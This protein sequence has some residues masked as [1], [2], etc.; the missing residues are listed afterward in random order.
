MAFGDL[1]G[2]LSAA[3]AAVTATNS[4]TGSVS[5]A[6]GDLVFLTF[7]QQANLRA[8]TVV[9]NLGNTY[10]ATNA[11]T[12]AGNITGRSYYSPVTVAGTLTSIDVSVSATSNDDW[13]GFAAV[14]EGPFQAA[15][16]DK[17]I[18]NAS[19]DL[20]SPFTCPATGA[21]TQAD[22][23]IIAWMTSDGNA[24]WLATSPNLKAG[25]VAN[26][27]TI[28]AIVGYQA[29]SATTTV[30]PEFTGTNPGFSVLGTSTFMKAAG[31]KTIAIDTGAHTFAGTAV[32]LKQARKVVAGSG[33]HSFSG[34]NVTLK[35]G[36]KVA[37]GTG[38][39]S[40]TG[41]SVTLRHAWRV[42]AG[43]GA[44]T[45][46]GT[47]VNLKHG[48]K[49][50]AGSGAHTFAGTDVTL[51]LSATKKIIAGAGAHSFAG[52]AV[53]LR[54]AWRL[55]AGAG[56][57]SFTGTSVTLKHA[58]KIGVDIGAHTF[59]GTDI[60]VTI[61]AAPAPPTIIR[62]GG[63]DRK[64]YQ[65]RQQESREELQRII[66]Q[67]WRIA[68]GE[69]DPITLEAIPPPPPPDYSLVQDALAAQAINEDQQRIEAFIS[70]QERM[71]QDEAIAVLLL[72]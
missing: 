72:S 31:N 59:A 18:A 28:K 36:F 12:D 61:G 3:A 63:G 7:G 44:H 13:A 41:T 4:V 69:I 64:D 1:K 55:N 42:V 34:T 66:D 5:V 25:Q 14:I 47:S 49:V 65:T 19:N 50:S 39:H 48:W 10:T 17:N 54:H 38:A 60:A 9:D 20:T 29:V 35:R 22:E 58:W 27:T 23:V 52:T 46:A 71:R 40:F 21:L 56:A 2:T 8:T 16:L 68:N 11:G 43:S 53:T 26:S 51:T 6:V 57:H 45:F 70:A 15:P 30:S 24:V 37:A 33:A 62:H 67:A 32:T